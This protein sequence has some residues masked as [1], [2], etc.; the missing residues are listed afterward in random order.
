MA[1][2]AVASRI[3][4]APDRS[5]R[6]RKKARSAG[7]C[8]AIVPSSR[9]SHVPPAIRRARTWRT[10]R[11]SSCSDCLHVPETRKARSVLEDR[12]AFI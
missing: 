9:G 8:P 6:N 7:R 2:P 10:L 12:R 11:F 4:E 1:A 3:V 5:F